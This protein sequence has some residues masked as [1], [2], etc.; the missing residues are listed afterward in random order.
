MYK[1]ANDHYFQ[2]NAIFYISSI[3]QNSPKNHKP[4]ITPRGS[5]CIYRNNADE[6]NVMESGKF[7]TEIY[8]GASAV[9]MKVCIANLSICLSGLQAKATDSAEGR[10]RARTAEGG[11]E[12]PF[13]SV[14]SSLHGQLMS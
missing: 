6:N 9:P 3:H 4:F 7:E 14:T 12:A 13:G 11:A 8:H 2:G 10:V 5:K 1:T